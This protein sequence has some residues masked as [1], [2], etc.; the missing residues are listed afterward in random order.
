MQAILWKIISAIMSVVFFISGFIPGSNINEPK[1]VE[2]IKVFDDIPSAFACEEDCVI[3]SSYDEWDGFL[4]K[5]GYTNERDEFISSVGESFFKENN[6]VL[7]EVGLPDTSYMTKVISAVQQGNTLSVELI[8]LSV[9]LF[10]FT[11]LCYSE[12]FITTSKLVTKVEVTELDSMVIPFILDGSMEDHFSIVDTE[13]HGLTEEFSGYT[14]VFSDFEGW[15]EFLDSGKY[16]FEE[17][18]DT[19]DENYFEIKNLVAVIVSKNAREETRIEYPDI[20]DDNIMIDYY[21]VSQPGIYPDNI[22][23]QTI[24]VETNK[25][26]STV[27]AT[28]KD[29]NFSVPFVLD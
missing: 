27:T 25:N 13:I 19:I 29:P 21:L 6:L 24:F 16:E 14:N 3:F 26:I 5:T 28:L 11:I 22:T 18:A 2:D 15:K 20:K 1:P 4:E 8:P 17:Y 9:D 23:Y 10:G 12:V 7:I